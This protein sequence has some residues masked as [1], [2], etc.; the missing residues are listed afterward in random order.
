MTYIDTFVADVQ[1]G[2]INFEDSVS[3]IANISQAMDKVTREEQP[4]PGLD[5]EAIVD[6]V[7]AILCMTL[8]ITDEDVSPDSSLSDFGFNSISLTEFSKLL[9][10]RYGQLN[11]PPS[12]FLENPSIEAVAGFIA[13]SCGAK[14]NANESTHSESVHDLI[15][16]KIKEHYEYRAAHQNIELDLE[17][18]EAFHPVSEKK[19]GISDIAIIGMGG[20]FPQSNDIA[21]FWQG[22]LD[23]RS[24]ISEIPK[25]RWDWQAI[26][27]EP[28]SPNKTDCHHG[29]FIDGI[30]EFDPLHFNIA[31]SDAALMDPQH[32]LAMEVVWE[33]LENAGY[34]PDQLRREKI[35]VFLGIERKDYADRIREQGIEV[36]GYLNTGNAHAML[37]NRIAHFFDWTG[38][39]QA[40]DAACSSSFVALDEAIHAVRSG[41]ANVALAGGVHLTLSP[42]VNIYNR[43]LGLFTG[44]G[45][46]RPFDKHADGHFFSDG[47]GAVLIK[48]LADA[49]RDGD[50]IYGVI[51]G[52]SVRHG[53]QSLFLTAP[54]S[55]IHETVIKDALT[56]ARLEARDIDYIE[57][58]G[59][60]NPIGDEIEL[61]AFSSVYTQESAPH[62]GS[63]KGHVGHFSGASGI[64]S[65]IKSILCLKNDTLVKTANFTALNWNDEQGTFP[66]QI[67][68]ETTQWSPKLSNGKRV[69]RHIG[70]HNYGFGGITGHAILAEYLG[71]KN[72]AATEKGSK[73]E[74]AVVLSAKSKAQLSTQAKQLYAY[75]KNGTS[76]IFGQNDTDLRDLAFTL[77]TGRKAYE[78]RLVIFAVSTEELQQ[79][80]ERYCENHIDER[81]VL[82][83]SASTGKDV[84]ALFGSKEMVATLAT[85]V[86]DRNIRGLGQVW[87]LGVS[88]DW[89]GLYSHAPKPRRVALPTHPFE[90][91][92]LWFTQVESEINRRTDIK[93]ESASVTPMLHVNTSSFFGQSYLSHFSSYDSCFDQ[94]NHN[95]TT[96]F[97][98]L[99]YLQMAAEA[100]SHALQVNGELVNLSVLDVTFAEPLELEQGNQVSLITRVEPN[101][102]QSVNCRI[103]RHQPMDSPIDEEEMFSATLVLEETLAPPQVDRDKLAAGFEQCEIKLYEIDQPGCVDTTDAWISK[104]LLPAL[105]LPNTHIQS[106]NN[107]VFYV[108]VGQLTKSAAFVISVIDTDNGN[109]LNVNVCDKEDHLLLS[110]HGLLVI[111]DSAQ[112]AITQEPTLERMPEEFRGMIPTLNGTGA[113]TTRLPACSG[114]FVDYAASTGDEVLDMGCAYG[115]ASIAALER[116]ARVLAVDIEQQHLSILSNLVEPKLQD[117][118]ELL[119]GKLPGLNLPQNRFSA[120]HA[121]RVLH[122]LSPDDFS[123]SIR[124]MATWLKP[125]GKL[126]IVCDSPYFPHWAARVSEYENLKE[127]GHS[128]PGYIDDIAAFFAQQVHVDGL[129]SSEGDHAEDA[130]KGTPFINLVDPDVLARECEAAGLLVEM[131]GYEGLAL[132]VDGTQSDSGLEHASII[133][134]KPLS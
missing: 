9:S 49:E 83:R 32:R 25:Q 82:E 46:V 109:W 71:D 39:A 95:G 56:E 88:V 29:A 31:P 20:R 7:M 78:Y 24:F 40:V 120:I 133:A 112:K 17:P 62:L 35:G 98:S 37:V 86:T 64:I 50:E 61:K 105:A 134:V 26:F 55:E 18:N 3:I 103:L 96:G 124:K 129:S 58:Q 87:S 128:W 79:R 54:N 33:T 67:V 108:P 68:T 34:N 41:R 16:D 43:K 2:L 97:H 104:V 42:D 130:L 27:G 6:D 65:L 110:L 106:L 111:E 59:T 85:W 21:D 10:L 100:V 19:K 51:R 91:K 99:C 132:D 123:A 115:V 125:G 114:M 13:Q 4:E 84:R 48:P 30:D 81:Y 117:R 93:T 102:D 116:G 22:L 44:E 38:P 126:F 15:S 23:N 118:L 77:Q 76:N 131:A 66:C 69:P 80:L 36:D 28:E 47:L 92:K 107:A 90:R 127:A 74:H 52:M 12:F 75:L 63:I 73:E 8:G 57:A 94:T 72:Q 11:L 119:C 89:S 113:M 14:L 122:F 1:N 53:G 101:A 5:M 45:V 121:A 60:A 70:V